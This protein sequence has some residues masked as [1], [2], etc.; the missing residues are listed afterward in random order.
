MESI[1]W[2]RKSAEQ[3]NQH[4]QMVLGECYLLGRGVPEDRAEAI[5]LLR[6]SAEQG[7]EPAIDLL[8]EIGG[9]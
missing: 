4:S 9:W 3:G 5:N 8:Q 2:L 7:Y 1:K 6:K